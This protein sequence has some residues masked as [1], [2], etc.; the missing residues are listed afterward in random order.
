MME[1]KQH[2]FELP[3]I[4]KVQLATVPESLSLL[5]RFLQHLDPEP[6]L[7]A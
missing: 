7:L 1:I 5:Q 3:G 4:V 2:E 6:H